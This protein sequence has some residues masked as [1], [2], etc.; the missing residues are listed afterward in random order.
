MRIQVLFTI[1]CI[2]F[3]KVA[4]SIQVE[5]I[6]DISNGEVKF[7]FDLYGGAIT[8]YDD[9]LIVVNNASIEE[10]EISEDGGLS[11]ISWFET[12]SLFFSPLM[13][14]HQDRLYIF[15]NIQVDEI[16]SCLSV[17]V[18]DL[19]SKPMIEITDLKV[20][21]IETLGTPSICF[22]GNFF[23]ISFLEIGGHNYSTAKYSTENLTFLG[24]IDHALGTS[25]VVIKDNMVATLWEDNILKFHHF[26]NDRLTYLNEID[27][28][29]YLEGV[30]TYHF[31]ETNLVITHTKGAL[32]YDIS[33]VQNPILVGNIVPPII[34]GAVVSHATFDG[35]YVAMSANFELFLYTLDNAGEFTL[36]VVKNDDF[37]IGYRNLAIA[38]N[39]LCH[40]RGLNLAV[41]DLNT[42]NLTEVYS[43]GYNIR[44]LYYTSAQQESFF[45][46]EPNF[47]DNSYKVYSVLDNEIIAVVNES[48][49]MGMIAKFQVDNGRLYVL[50]TNNDSSV[51]FDIFSI[52][53]AQATLLKRNTFYSNLPSYFTLRNDIIFFESSNGID[54][55]QLDDYNMK[56]IDSISGRIADPY[57]NQSDDFIITVSSLDIFFRDLNNHYN[58]FFSSKLQSQS[59]MLAYIDDNH[60]IA[61]N[62]MMQSERRARIVRYSNENENT[63]VIYSFPAHSQPTV[64][65]DNNGIII[66]NADRKI[67]SKYYAILNNA[68]CEIGQKDDTNKNV[69]MTYFYIEKRKMVQ[70][71]TSAIWVYDFDFKPYVSGDDKVVTLS[72]TELLSNYPNPF[73]PETTIRFSVTAMPATAGLHQVSIDIFNV[74]GQKVRTLVN[75]HMPAGEH[76]V[77]WNGRDDGGVQVGS[78][79]YFY[80]MTSGGYSTTKKMVLLK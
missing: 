61:Y 38:N 76:S 80:R 30:I 78:G 24:F 1:L 77:V 16:S 50:A 63:Q 28:S 49:P 3:I 44:E 46:L 36:S 72:Q 10:F 67:M 57:S 75:D 6:T 66:D 68:L 15:R 22:Q 32:I 71:T 52:N 14:V 55:Y 39:F 26:E 48:I 45:F 70:V 64:W 43:H 42:S 11:R 47:Q 19:T 27:L 23:Y 40:Q 31:F 17:R 65:T 54:V 60:L 20:P 13:N 33:D 51:R 79:I 37:A 34:E 7:T 29:V 8:Y 35:R 4:Y 73:N 18:F 12:N 21:E 25:H 74:K 69:K 56:R 2:I 62:S 59:G 9:R 5:N 41:Y 53:S 58:I